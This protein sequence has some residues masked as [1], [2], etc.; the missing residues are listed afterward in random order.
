MVHISVED[1]CAPLYCSCNFSLIFGPLYG[2]FI[3]I[4]SLSIRVLC[5]AKGVSHG[6]GLADARSPLRHT[7]CHF[8]SL[9]FAN[10]NPPVLPFCI[11]PTRRTPQFCSAKWQWAEKKSCDHL[12]YSIHLHCDLG[13]HTLTRHLNVV[14]SQLARKYIDSPRIHPV[15]YA[16]F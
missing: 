12:M 7:Y 3:R 5:L 11:Q 2:C 16:Y 8:T 15:Y 14:L 6:A 4:I 9:A 13:G 10:L 1:I